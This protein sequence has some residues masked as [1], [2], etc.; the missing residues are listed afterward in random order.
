MDILSRKCHKVLM[1]GDVHLALDL[2]GIR[3]QKLEIGD[4]SSGNRV[5]DGH[6]RRLSLTGGHSLEQ[7]L[8]GRTFHNRDLL[9]SR[10]IELPCRLLV[11]AP[12]VTLYR[13]F[14]HI[15]H[16]FTSPSPYGRD[17]LSPQR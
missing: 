4:E 17:L 2:V 14:C 10:G 9:P 15:H 7:S 8:E 3:S 16:H 12:S 13:D 11:E 6:H 5:L 1:Y